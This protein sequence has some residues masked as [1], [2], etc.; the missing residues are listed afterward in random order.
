MKLQRK[1]NDFI[2]S[3][4]S[5]TRS[6]DEY[7][8]EGGDFITENEN[9]HIKGHLGLGVPTLQHWIRAIR[10]HEKLKGNCVDV[11]E[12]TGLKDPGLQSGSIFKFD[13]KVQMLRTIICDSSILDDCYSQLL[14]AIDGTLLHHDLVNFMYIAMENYNLL[15]ENQEADLQPVFVIYEDEN[16][17]NDV[18]TWIV[19]KIWKN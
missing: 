11:F 4:K 6:G 14:K 1:F 10:N 8:G 13:I 7:R 9:K 19:E 5:F 2:T 16:I 12:R 15:I 17:Y 18:K 3:S